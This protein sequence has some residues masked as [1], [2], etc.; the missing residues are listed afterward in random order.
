MWTGGSGDYLLLRFAEGLT[1]TCEGAGVKVACVPSSS[2]CVD[3]V[4]A[5]S[6]HE[7]MVLDKD[8][9]ATYVGYSNCESVTAN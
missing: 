2:N 1:H 6:T 8:G 7:Y 5:A 3:I 4:P 9:G